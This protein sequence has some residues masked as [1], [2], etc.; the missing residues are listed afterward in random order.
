MNIMK[1]NKITLEQLEELEQL[2]LKLKKQL[3]EL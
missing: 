2:I 1:K 3:Q